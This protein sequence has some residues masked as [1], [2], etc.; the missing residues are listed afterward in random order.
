MR[1]KTL[2]IIPLSRNKN[3]RGVHMRKTFYR[4]ARTLT[5]DQDTQQHLDG[6]SQEQ[7]RE[8]G[9]STPLLSIKGKHD[10]VPFGE[11]ELTFIC[12]HRWWSKATEINTNI[13]MDFRG[14]WIRPIA[15]WSSWHVEVGAESAS[16]HSSW[17]FA[18]LLTPLGE[19]SLH[20]HHPDWGRY[21]SSK[22]GQGRT[23]VSEK[24]R[25]E[26]W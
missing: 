23:R 4:S 7:S 17:F 16:L 26:G 20:H 19:E 12:V 21:P 18:L 11:K 9:I 2:C 25:G 22:S 24:E 15:I 6:L 10:F 3:N 5:T 13:C 1:Q 14:P 8:D